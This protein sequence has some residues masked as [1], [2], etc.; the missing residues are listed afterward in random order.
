MNIAPSVSR[1]ISREATYVA[2]SVVGT[3]S[4]QT[5][6]SAVLKHTTSDTTEEALF[7]ALASL[8]VLTS[9]VAM[10]LDKAWRNRLFSRLDRIHEPAQWDQAD[11]PISAGSF[12]TFLR[13]MFLLKPDRQA[14]I[15]LANEGHLVASWINGRDRLTIECLPKDQVKVVLTRWLGSERDSAAI[16]TNIDR[17]QRVLTAY[18][19][20]CWFSAA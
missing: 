12:L 10:H 15:S 14:N 1:G 7:T 20:A 19:P 3:R 11:D 6:A 16:L 4:G 17:V 2:D 5:P 13:L 9:Q 18:D 8:K